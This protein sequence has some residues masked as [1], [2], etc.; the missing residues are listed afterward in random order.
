MVYTLS[1]SL[2]ARFTFSFKEALSLGIVGYILSIDIYAAQH[3]E[4]LDFRRLNVAKAQAPTCVKIR[5]IGNENDA[6]NAQQL[7]IEV[8]GQKSSKAG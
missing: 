4:R 5:F 8:L 2:A 7:D 1:A 6:F 3:I